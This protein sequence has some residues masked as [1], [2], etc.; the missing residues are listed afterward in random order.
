MARTDVPKSF[1]WRVSPAS[2]SLSRASY[3]ERAARHERANRGVAACIER[4]RRLSSGVGWGEHTAGPP[5]WDDVSAA[6]TL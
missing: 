1:G 6:S 2:G 4:R 3:P 5:A